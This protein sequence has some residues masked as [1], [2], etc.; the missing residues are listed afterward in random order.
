MVDPL[1]YLPLQADIFT[2][3]LDFEPELEEDSALRGIIGGMRGGL[4]DAKA[5]MALGTSDIKIIAEDIGCQA[6]ILAHPI[7]IRVLRIVDE[8]TKAKTCKSLWL[9][10]VLTNYIMSWGNL[11]VI[12]LPQNYSPL[13]TVPLGWP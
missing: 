7:M 6:G 4:C 5:L 9:R 13:C 11:A 10:G 2:A 8:P 1:G 12:N 3:A